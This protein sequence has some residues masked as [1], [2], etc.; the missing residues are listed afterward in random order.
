MRAADDFPFIRARV[1]QLQRERH[2]PFETEPG[3]K[4]R[5]RS[6]PIEEIARVAQQR[7]R[8]LLDRA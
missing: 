3:P 4:H 8:E 5:V 7:T 2:A 1:E 6:I